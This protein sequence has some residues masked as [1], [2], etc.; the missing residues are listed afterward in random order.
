MWYRKENELFCERKVCVAKN[1]LDRVL[2][3]IHEV[4]GH[5]GPQRTVLMFAQAFYCV[6]PRSD[7][8]SFCKNLLATCPNCLRIKQNNPSDRGLVSA[9]PIPQIANDLLYIDFVQMDDFNHHNYVL[10]I[11]DALTKFAMFIPCTKNITGE[12][13]LKLVHKEWISHYGK[14]SEILSDN[15]VRFT[16]SKGFY[17]EAFKSL[18]IE[19]KF[20]I[21]RHPQSNGLCERTNRSFIQNIRSLS[22]DCNTLDWPK[23]T[24]F[25]TWLHNSQVSPQTGY[26]PS[27]LFLGRPSWKFS[28]VPEPSSNPSVESWLEDQIF[29]QEKAQKR[30][31]HLRELSL[32]RANKGR[33]PCKI[34][35]GDFV[36]VHKNRWP[37]KPIPKLESPWLGPF[38]V[39]HVHHSSLKVFVSP[40]LGGLVD[41]SLSMV[42]KW[43]P[44]NEVLEED[45]ESVSQNQEDEPLEVE[46]EYTREE[47]EE[48]GFYN[49]ERILKHKY[50][51]GWRFLTQWEGY[52]LSAA[53]WEP[54]KSLRD[55]DLVVTC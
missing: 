23:L 2:T 37:Q 3:W 45:F 34:V 29:M 6:L 46:N 31:E 15:D 5:P 13:T 35:E 18:G 51:Q 4:S 52:P 50:L 12:L 26:S 10:T 30:L 22:L 20:G 14:P 49:V 25:V 55:W 1:F 32:R 7:L 39:H 40:S 36:L 44:E 21:P 19:V 47:Q 9:L 48:M 28:T 53:T 8:L 17:Q 54:I 24:P 43:N 41:V 11:V 42:K 38:K 27:E 16:S 33:K